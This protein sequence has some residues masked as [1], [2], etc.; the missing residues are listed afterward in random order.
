M[1]KKRTILRFDQCASCRALAI[2]LVRQ[3]ANS[4]YR[5]K[6]SGGHKGPSWPSDIRAAGLKWNSLSAKSWLTYL[7]T[8]YKC[9]RTVQYL[10]C[11]N[12]LWCINFRLNNYS[13]LNDDNAWHCIQYQYRWWWCSHVRCITFGAAQP[14]LRWAATCHVR[15]FVA[16]TT[17]VPLCRYSIT[18]WTSMEYQ[19]T[20]ILKSS[21]INRTVSTR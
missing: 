21:I 13:I 8:T 1:L 12:I 4:T 9:S 15:P 19:V 6:Q 2:E 5:S 10:S 14:S 11:Y 16:G 20:R 7:T 3:N 17:A 18:H